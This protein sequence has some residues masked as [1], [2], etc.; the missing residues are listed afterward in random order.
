MV[1]RYFVRTGDETF[2]KRM[3]PNVADAMKYNAFLDNDHD[4]LVNEHPHALPGENWPANQFYDQ[5]PWHRDE[6]VCGEHGAGGGASGGGD[7]GSR[8]G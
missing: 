3:W 4:G 6:R 5:W 7:G 8:G 1:H 2:L